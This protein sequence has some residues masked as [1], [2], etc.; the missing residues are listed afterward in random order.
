MPAYKPGQGLSNEALVRLRARKQGTEGAVELPAKDQ[1]QQWDQ[2]LGVGAKKKP[3]CGI[4]TR[5]LG[6]EELVA[7]Q[8]VCDRCTSPP[9]E[10]FVSES[11]RL[12][13]SLA[14]VG[15]PTPST[16]ASDDSER[17]TSDIPRMHSPSPAQVMLT[18]V[19]KALAGHWLDDNH[20]T[21]RI[22][23]H[24]ET[25]WTC[26]LEGA[27]RSLRF[28]LS[29]DARRNVIWW[30]AD[31]T[32]FIDASAVFERPDEIRWYQSGD[33]ERHQ[34]E[35]AWYRFSPAEDMNDYEV[36]KSSAIEEIE[37]QLLSPGNDGRVRISL[38]DQRY[39]RCLGSLKNFLAS[40]PDKFTVIPG[41]GYRFTV[42]P[43]CKA[44]NGSHLGSIV[45]NA[46]WEIEDQLYAPDSKGYIW[47]NR[48]NER[49]LPYLGTLRDFLESR[50]DKFNVIPGKGKGF[51]VWPAD[52][53]TRQGAHYGRDLFL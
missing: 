30:G 13:E 17:S 34:P 37:E 40:C 18:A 46:I 2:L 51:Q 39:G 24:E 6:A 43:V 38:W 29:Y 19:K 12:Q 15:C 16:V 4:C 33:T 22:D 5:P 3:R 48:W 27:D 1:S 26:V 45:A 21:Y 11:K 31:K 32:H 49:Y 10:G 44:T 20:G 8:L 23:F 41:D 9:A 7:K 25:R 35:F 53:R 28:P 50:P 47:I 52:R 42:T 14:P 36:C